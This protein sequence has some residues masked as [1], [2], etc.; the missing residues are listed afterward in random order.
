MFNI[1][2]EG[3]ASIQVYVSQAP[4][5]EELKLQT[6]IQP[7]QVTKMKVTGTLADTDWRLIRENMISLT[8]LDLSAIT[9]TE[10][11]DEALSNMAYLTKLVLPAKTTSIGNKAFYDNSLMNVT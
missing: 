6:G 1:I 8:E 7:S 9:N 10:I 4:I 3:E 5:S 11:P 2:E